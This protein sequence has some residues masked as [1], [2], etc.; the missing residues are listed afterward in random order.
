[1]VNHISRH[2]PEF[3]DFE[4]TGGDRR[5]ADLFITIDKVWPGGDPPPEDLARLFLRKP[6]GPFSTITIGRQRA[7]ERVWTTFGSED[8]LS[9]ST[10]T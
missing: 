9:R 2:S 7:Q 1:M 4:R 3:R 10:W 5:Y 6:D 8:G